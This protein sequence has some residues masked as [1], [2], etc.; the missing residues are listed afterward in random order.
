MNGLNQNVKYSP[1]HTQKKDREIGDGKTEKR[2]RKSEGGGELRRQTKFGAG[3]VER[4]TFL[5]KALT[6]N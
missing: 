3:V 4:G 2:I 6:A 1:P 5:F